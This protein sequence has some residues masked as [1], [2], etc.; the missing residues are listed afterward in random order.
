MLFEGASQLAKDG[1]QA[2]RNARI[3]AAIEAGKVKPLSKAELQA[4]LAE[5]VRN[6][7]AM[8]SQNG[9]PHGRKRSISR[10]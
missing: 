2:L 6:T 9:G 7:A 3:R 8:P 5:A 1:T 10:P 4:M